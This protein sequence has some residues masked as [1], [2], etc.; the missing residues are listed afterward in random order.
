MMTFWIV[1]EVG[2]TWA[3]LNE[4]AA[5]AFA[6]VETAGGAV[7]VTLGTYDHIIP[8][9]NLEEV[10]DAACSNGFT[11]FIERYS[12]DDPDEVV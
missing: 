5:R 7:G 9:L 11:S 3:F 2:A 1:D 8:T 4:E 12:D 10:A 6:Q